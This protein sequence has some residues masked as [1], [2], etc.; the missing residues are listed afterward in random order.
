VVWKNDAAFWPIKKAKHRAK[1]RQKGTK[2]P[3][4]HSHT[5]ISCDNGEGTKKWIHKEIATLMAYSEKTAKTHYDVFEQEM[6]SDLGA[7]KI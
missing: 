4:R 1:K 3:N 6:A 5:Q 7:E 2:K